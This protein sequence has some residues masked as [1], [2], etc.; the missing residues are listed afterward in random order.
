MQRDQAHMENQWDLHTERQLSAAKGGIKAATVLDSGSWLAM[1]TQADKLSA[2]PNPDALSH[3]R[4]GI[5]RARWN[6][7]MAVPILG[8]GLPSST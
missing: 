3:T 6:A 2:G 5:R 8:H 1:L 7:A 4:K